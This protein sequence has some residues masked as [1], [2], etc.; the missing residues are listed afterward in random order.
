MAKNT[1]IP[2]PQVAAALLDT[3]NPFPPTFLHRFSDL[4]G[5]DLA[6]LQQIW[7]RIATTRKLAL[8]E[9]LEELAE[10][11]TLVLFDSVA[12]TGLTD[13]E[14]RIRAA[15][16]HMLWENDTPALA[17]TFIQMLQND[18]NALVRAAAAAGLGWFVYQGELESL[19]EPHLRKVEEA[20]LQA[21]VSAKDELVQR[22]A[23]ESLG[24]SS[25]EE[26]PALIQKA[27]DTADPDWISSALYAMGRSLDQVWE[28]PVRRMLNNPKANVQLEAIRAAG[29]LELGSTRRILLDLLEEEAQ[30][31]EV[32]GATIWSLSQIGGEEVRETLEQIL[33][34]TE[35]E[36]EAELVENALDN[37]T[38]TESGD[39]F[40]MYDFG[41]DHEKNLTR[42]VNL[43]KEEGE[44]EAEIDGEQL[45]EDEEEDEG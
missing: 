3:E 25:R 12:F 24:Y 14:P 6:S 26:V 22:R 39:L 20:L 5:A 9:D 35:D 15:C 27:Y 1:K 44:D 16:I 28:T 19:P 36:D 38:L 13:E 11:D 34:H 45:F 32:R 8:L 29:S 40:T 37:L 2:F 4:E 21:A 30:D 23:I 41:V 33:Q 10:A 31:T 18:P 17:Y 7:P 43:E 42:I